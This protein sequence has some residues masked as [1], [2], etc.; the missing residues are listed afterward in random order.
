MQAAEK[1]LFVRVRR[2]GNTLGSDL[3]EQGSESGRRNAEFLG[4]ASAVE[5][6]PSRVQRGHGFRISLVSNGHAT[7]MLPILDAGTGIVV[8]GIG[9]RC[10]MPTRF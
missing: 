5:F 4:A 2:S 9:L 1:I 8:F 6:H 10:G 7:W 3:I